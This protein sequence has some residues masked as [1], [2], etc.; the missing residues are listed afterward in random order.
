MNSSTLIK[1]ICKKQEI[2]LKKGGLLKT[3]EGEQ[4]FLVLQLET[5]L[6]LEVA[7]EN[8]ATV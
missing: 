6:G 3:P 7:L 1:T 5:R 8:S 4:H 2:Q